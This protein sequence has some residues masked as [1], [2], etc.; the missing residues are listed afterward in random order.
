MQRICRLTAAS[1]AR[2][3][4]VPATRLVCPASPRLCFC[5]EVDEQESQLDLLI[6]QIPHPSAFILANAWTS[7]SLKQLEMPN[8][9]IL[10]NGA[11]GIPA[12]PYQHSAQSHGCAVP[13]PL[14]CYKGSLVGAFPQTRT[15]LLVLSAISCAP[16][17]DRSGMQSLL[18]WGHPL[19]HLRAGI[20][21]PPVQRG[22]TYLPR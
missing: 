7:T 17:L 6:F 8:D 1:A 14:L 5:G 18:T 3:A 11:R 4:I 13:G 19:I 10:G 2:F 20:S 15:D 16:R 21:L 22:G 9:I 12:T